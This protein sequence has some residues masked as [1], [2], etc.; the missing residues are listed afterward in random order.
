VTRADYT[1]WTAAAAALFAAALIYYAWRTP[2]LAMFDWARA[3]GLGA[4]TA[5]LRASLSGIV[6]PDAVLYSLP[7]ALWQYTFAFALFRIS[8]PARG[9]ERALF[10]A[11]PIVIGVGLELGQLAG[12]IEGT[13][14]PIDLTLSAIAIALA[15]LLARRKTA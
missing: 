13:F 1:R 14:D 5:S 8:L 6:L 15:W 12:A 7:D 4:A 11:A 2:T 10:C 9:I 3:L